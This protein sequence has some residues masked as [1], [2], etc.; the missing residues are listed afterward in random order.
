MVLETLWQRL[1][2]ALVTSSENFVFGIADVFVVL[3]FLLLGW[4]VGKILAGVAKRFMEKMEIEQSL[5]KRGI[6][7]ELLGFTLTEV[8]TK[9]VKVMTYA[10]FLGI[11]ADV[12]NLRFLGDL[13]MWFVGYIPL[14]LQGATIIV[15]AL[16][17]G[18]YI[19]ARVR[20][21]GMPFANGVAF[22]FEVFVAYTALVISLPLVLPNAD[23][24]ILN[25][26]LMLAIGAVALALGLGGAIAI[27]L[28]TKDTV[29]EIAKKKRKDIERLI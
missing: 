26:V 24:Q 16:L 8:I 9:F 28:G 20:K 21:S 10:V 22:V 23:V 27:G 7:D 15:L 14:F 11:A 4:I 2:D 6:H 18:G 13:V 25:N 12:V 19:T 3:L 17:G 29:S 1:S 5:R